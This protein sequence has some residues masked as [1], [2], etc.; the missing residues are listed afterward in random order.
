MSLWF[1]DLYNILYEFIAYRGRGDVTDQNSEYDIVEV[2]PFCFVQRC[3]VLTWY[4]YCK[5]TRALVDSFWL[6]LLLMPVCFLV[7]I[8]NSGY[9]V[10]VF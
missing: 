3:L 7:I 1:H 9:N 6:L 4:N 2:D 10:A 8:L 5:H